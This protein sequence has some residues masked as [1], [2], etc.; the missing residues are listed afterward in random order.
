MYEEE[1][2]KNIIMNG[3][4]V[5]MWQSQVEKLNI[6]PLCISTALLCL[7]HC[8]AELSLRVGLIHAAQ[9]HEYLISVCSVYE[10]H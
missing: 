8:S 1:S 7:K 5:S 10:L 6:I 4:P 9:V 3:Q 2:H